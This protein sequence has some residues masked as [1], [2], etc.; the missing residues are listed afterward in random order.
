M[1]RAVID[2][3]GGARWTVRARYDRHAP[4]D[5]DYNRR[6]REPGLRTRLGSAL[7]P[8]PGPL[9][10]A[11][12]PGCGSSADSDERRRAALADSVRV[13][14]GLAGLGGPRFLLTALGFGIGALREPM[15]GS[16]VVELRARGR[17][18]RGATWRMGSRA[19]AERT[20]GTV[21][22]AV[23]VAQVPQPEGT[24]LVDVLDERLTV[25]GAPR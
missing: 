18:R 16:W 7:G 22:E 2:D 25:H 21:A 17:I 4:L 9:P 19:D 23:R 11:D 8:Q 6:R 15:D 1:S 20:L 24:L 5:S 10:G 14:G 13:V 12:E 3:C